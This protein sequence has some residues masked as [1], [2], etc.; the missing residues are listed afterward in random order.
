MIKVITYGTF[1]LLHKGHIRL[2]QRAKDLGD[3]LI[4]GITSS[5]FDKSRGKAN[6]QQSLI[7][8]ID[9]IS[10]LGIADEIIV[11]EYDG[12][13]IDDILKYNID[14]F[15]VG[16]DWEGQ[17]DYL[18]N[19]CKVIYLERTKGVSSTKIRH[20]TN[21]LR[22][23]FIGEWRDI[24]KLYRVA[25]DSNIVDVA[26]IFKG[27]QFC[28][29]YDQQESDIE[30]TLNHFLNNIDC[31]YISLPPTKHYELIKFL[32]ENQIHVLY[33]SPLAL[34]VEQAKE[35]IE[36]A[37]KNQIVLQEGLK[38]AYTL[39]YERLSLLIKSGKI[40]SITQIDS[41]CTSLNKNRGIDTWGS[42]EGW[43]P[44]ALYPI[45]DLLGTD[46][47]KYFICTLDNLHIKSDDF[48]SIFQILNSP[49]NNIKTVATAKIGKGVKSEGNL[50]ITGTNGY[51]Y[52]PAPWWKTEYFEIR[53]ENISDRQRFFYKSQDD[54]LLNELINF[55]QRVKG[56]S[57]K[58]YI[59]T[60]ITLMIVKILELYFEKGN[61]II[62]LTQEDDV[63]NRET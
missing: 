58:I 17:F 1:D 13:K 63:S 40:G 34:K 18:N 12:Q 56:I 10:K 16:S 41:T 49:Y 23:G 51:V 53:G 21:V 7:E 52:V 60:D 32:L 45:Y 26:G 19:Y 47:I 38:T 9:A 14:I 33:E 43:G 35:L 46:V 20:D 22:M 31:V 29:D 27:S 6:V 54:G 57:N 61:N 59:S 48:T 44:T 25:V 2:L 8:R 28:F 30:K 4:V 3:Y 11:E 50:I 5:D 36:I 55:C 42:L 62:S 24:S 39:A 15:T 37:R